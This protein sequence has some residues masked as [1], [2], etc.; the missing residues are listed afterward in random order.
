[1]L[2]SLPPRTAPQARVTGKQYMGWISETFD[3]HR[4]QG[5]TEFGCKDANDG[6]IHNADLQMNDA[7]IKEV[8]DMVETALKEQRLTLRRHPYQFEQVAW[9]KP[10]ANLNEGAAYAV[11]PEPRPGW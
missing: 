9:D 3:S 4:C 8:V 7:Q 2:L 10:P 11:K 6:Q 1:M 5:Q